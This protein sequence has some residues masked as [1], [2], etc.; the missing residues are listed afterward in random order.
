[1]ALKLVTTCT[2]LDD[3]GPRACDFSFRQNGPA[4]NGCLGYAA[5]KI[6]FVGAEP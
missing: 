3:P 6:A 1:M 4:N 2:I 5:A